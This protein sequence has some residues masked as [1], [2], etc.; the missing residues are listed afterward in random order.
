M[1]AMTANPRN[2]PIQ[3]NRNVLCQMKPLK[4]KRI[5]LCEQ[6]AMKKPTSTQ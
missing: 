2:H 1:K 4:G 5:I 6:K 3:L